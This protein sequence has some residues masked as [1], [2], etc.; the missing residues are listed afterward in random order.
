MLGASLVA[1]SVEPAFA[2][3]GGRMGGGGGARM[4]GGSGARMGGGTAPRAQPTAP[5][6][7]ATQATPAARPA[8]QQR[9]AGATGAGAANRAN[10]PATHSGR[11]TNI[12]NRRTNVNI[13]RSRD[14]NIQRNTV[15]R[16]GHGYRGAPYAHGGRRYYAHNRYAYHRYRG[17]GFGVGFYPFGAFVATMAATAIVVSAA[18]ASYYY[19]AGVWYLPAS[20]GYNVVTAPVG[21]T[22]ATVPSSAVVVNQT[23]N[24]YYYGGTYYE[25]SGSSYK[26]VPPTAGTV[27]E[28]LPEGG[29]EVTVG[30]RKY[31]KIGETYYQPI[32]KDGKQMY[33]VVEVK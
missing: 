4:G 18:N 5:S 11:T 28:N 7:P 33:E 17:F 3:G 27:V 24:T 20:G 26:V 8:A 21:A 15:V 2:R 6:R 14:V 9:P 22:V 1:G 13:D 16:G 19:N 30:D 23:N 12:D 31:V 32:E 25:K 29:E 10:S